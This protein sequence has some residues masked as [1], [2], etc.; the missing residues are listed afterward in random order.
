MTPKQRANR[1]AAASAKARAK[2]TAARDSSTNPATS[3][4]EY[5]A[6]EMEFMASIQAWKNRTG[7]QFPAWHEVLGVLK[8]LGYSK[9]GIGT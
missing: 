4:R 1:G 7:R 6:D 3:D 8:G 9:T 5:A 2:R